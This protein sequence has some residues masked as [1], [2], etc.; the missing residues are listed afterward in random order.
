MHVAL[1]KVKYTRQDKSTNVTPEAKNK[2]KIIINN[3]CIGCV[4]PR[5]GQQITVVRADNDSGG[6]PLLPD[7]L[8][9]LL[10]CQSLWAAKIVPEVRW[11]SKPQNLLWFYIRAGRTSK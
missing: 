10:R 9:D 4:S 8:A 11:D 3:V 5:K 2:L 7:S 1:L 6:G